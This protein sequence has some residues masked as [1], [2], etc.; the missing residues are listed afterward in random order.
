MNEY[1]TFVIVVA[2]AA[3]VVVV[4]VVVAAAEH[5]AASSDNQSA[6]KYK[7]CPIDINAKLKYSILKT[8]VV[9]IIPK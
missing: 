9:G 3:A 2:A 8:N 1:F 7:T 6:Q 5:N 4:V